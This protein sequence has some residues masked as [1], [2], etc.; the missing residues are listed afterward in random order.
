MN[1]FI[2]LLLGFSPTAVPQTTVISIPKHAKG[3][4]IELKRVNCIYYG[5]DLCLLLDN[6]NGNKN[7]LVRI[8]LHEVE[9]S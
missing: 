1:T 5:Y 9:Q 8:F 4:Q 7:H 2:L 6:S 3:F